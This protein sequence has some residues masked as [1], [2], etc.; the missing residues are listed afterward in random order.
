MKILPINNRVNFNG[1]LINKKAAKEIETVIKPFLKEYN[2]NTEELMEKVC[3]RR[4]LIRTPFFVLPAF[5]PAEF[6]EAKRLR[7]GEWSANQSEF[8]YLE[9]KSKKWYA[10]EDAALMAVNIRQSGI[11][12]VPD[13]LGEAPEAFKNLKRDIKNG[14]KNMT[15]AKLAPSIYA[16]DKKLERADFNLGFPYLYYSNI[17]RQ[18]ASLEEK[19]KNDSLTIEAYTE[20]KNKIEYLINK[21]KKIMPQIN[22][23]ISEAEKIYTETPVTDEDIALLSQLHKPAQRVIS[24]NVSKFNNKV[25]DINLNSEQAQ[26]LNE[27]LGKQKVSIEA[28]WN[29]IEEGK[30]NAFSRQEYINNITEF[31]ED[32]P[33]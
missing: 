12:D 11:F 5:D 19:V 21:H 3:K 6:K 4:N 13:F 25:K 30:T 8:N 15:F 23:A 16:K 1:A 31:N 27:L 2:P 7:L 29:K 14:L 33:F 17:L 9:E 26:A 24:R 28:L 22:E 32:L 10:G 18:T 20:A